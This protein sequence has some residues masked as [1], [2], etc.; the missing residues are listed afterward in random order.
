MLS[1]STRA[2]K[3]C[4]HVEGLWSHHAQADHLSV[5]RVKMPPVYT[6]TSHKYVYA[7]HI[8]HLQYFCGAHCLPAH[9]LQPL[10]LP[11]H[12]LPAHR[13]PSQTEHTKLHAVDVFLYWYVQHWPIFMNTLMHPLD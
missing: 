3:G 5:T 11:A 4:Q 1:E 10:N 12:C 2:V 13:L 9:C 6:W 8:R 7:I